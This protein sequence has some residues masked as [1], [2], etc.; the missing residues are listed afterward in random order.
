LSIAVE[1]AG[2]TVQ[3][4]SPLDNLVGFEHAPRNKQ[5]E[6]AGAGYG[7]KAPRRRYAVQGEPGGAVPAR[8]IRAGL[9]RR[10][11]CVASKCDWSH[12]NGNWNARWPALR[13]HWHG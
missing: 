5:Q 12:R 8:Q 13:R 2:F 10:G 4:E 6:Q 1:G 11:G 9:F 3:L 7:G